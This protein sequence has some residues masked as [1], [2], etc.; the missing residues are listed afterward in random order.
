[1]TDQARPATLTTKADFASAPVGT[2]VTYPY[3]GVA[4]KDGEDE[5]VL[6][7]EEVFCDD[8]AMAAEAA[9]TDKPCTVLRW[10]KEMHSGV[11]PIADTYYEYTAEIEAQHGAVYMWADD[12]NELYPTV[13]PAH[14]DWENDPDTAGDL[15]K[16]ATNRFGA[17]AHVVRRLVTQPEPTE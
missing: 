4:I 9:D 16:L 7:G 14:A 13:N 12:H 2:I 11:I 1:M 10:G 17:P 6:A 5:W 3:W 8:A 15:A